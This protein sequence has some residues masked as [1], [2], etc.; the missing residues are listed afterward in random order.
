MIQQSGSNGARS[1]VDGHGG[2]WSGQRGNSDFVMDG[3]TVPANKLY[4]PDKLTWN[5]IKAKY[6][7]DIDSIPYKNGEPDFSAVAVDTVKISN[8]STNRYNNFSQA[9][10]QLANKLGLNASDIEKLRKDNNLTWHERS[11]M[12]TMDLVPR[13][14]HSLPHSGGISNANK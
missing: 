12:A 5:E 1:P 4:N 10:R 2:N 3:N 13:E 14:Y 6:R 11:D 9:D 7:N 8:F